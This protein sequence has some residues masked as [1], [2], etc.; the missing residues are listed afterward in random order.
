[1]Q[2]RQATVDDAEAIANVHV[3][4][5]QETYRGIIPDD[6]LNQLSTEKRTAAWRELLVGGLVFVAVD[7]KGLIGFAH[8]KQ[9]QSESTEGELS[10]IY[11]LRSYQGRGIGRAL[12]NRVVRQLEEHGVTS[13][14]IAVLA[15]NPACHFYERLG[16][17]RVSECVIE[18]GGK[19]LKEYVYQV[20]LP[21][22]AS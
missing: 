1:M 20:A 4:A 10:A 2:I 8:G 3:S 19:E 22:A 6:Y 11:L 12:V 14:I 7:A 13:L 18:R 16:G 17:I 21:I 9:N 5:W 15:D